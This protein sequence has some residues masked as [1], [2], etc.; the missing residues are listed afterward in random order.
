MF[1]F[2]SKYSPDYSQNTFEGWSVVLVVAVGFVAS[3]FACGWFEVFGLFV[4]GALCA[5]IVACVIKFLVT[6][7]K[8]KR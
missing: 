5:H 2:L 7:Q 3:T 6:K 4:A 8:E 1:Q